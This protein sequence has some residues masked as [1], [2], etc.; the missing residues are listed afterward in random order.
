MPSTPVPSDPNAAPAPVPLDESFRQAW[1]R[2][3]TLVYTICGAIILAIIVK[4]AWEYMLAHKEFEIRREYAASSTAE[5]YRAFAASHPGHPLAAL[6]ELNVADDAYA[7]GHFS[8]AVADY[9]KAAS[10]LPTGPFRSRAKLGQAMAL[11]LSGKTADAET[12]L[13]QILNDPAQ[14]SALRCEAGYQLANLAVAANR[15]GEVEKLAEQMMQID[16]TNPY[17]ERTLQLHAAAPAQPVPVSAR[18]T[19]ALPGA[20]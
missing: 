4:G 1:E 19:I 16:P 13:R 10:D 11:A 15:P 8:D 3:G 5:S 12:S 6:A 2:H 14:L 17:A 7:S 20:H 9:D 18:P